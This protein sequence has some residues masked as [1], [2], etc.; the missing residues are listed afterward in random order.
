MEPEM[1]PE[2]IVKII[3]K[4]S[5]WKN[6][7]FS[8]PC[9]DKNIKKNKS[10]NK[11][12]DLIIKLN[13]IPILCTKFRFKNILKWI[14]NIEFGGILLSGGGDIGTKKLK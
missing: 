2:Q 6:S 9:Y 10:Y 1:K 7:C 13:F 14:K 3:S 8:R 11:L 4:I 5:K 12:L